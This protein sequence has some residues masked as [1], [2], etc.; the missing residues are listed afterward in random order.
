[1]TL[2]VDGSDYSY[3]IDS[4]INNSIYFGISKQD[5]NELYKK[6]TEIISTNW[7]KIARINEADEKEIKL[8]SLIFDKIV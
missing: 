4:I 3:N 2:S 6:F 7:K 5:A 1:M 8:M